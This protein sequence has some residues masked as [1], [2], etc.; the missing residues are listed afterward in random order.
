M[1][2]YIRFVMFATMLVGTLG[3]FCADSVKADQNREASTEVL[4]LGG[5]WS[6][7]IGASA[8]ERVTVSYLSSLLIGRPLP[9]DRSQLEP[10]T[11]VENRLRLGE[12][13]TFRHRTGFFREF[14]IDLQLDLFSGSF[15][16]TLDD[17]L[18]RYDPVQ[19]DGKGLFASTHHHLR[20]LSGEV[21]TMIGRISGGRTT[22]SWGLGILAQ[23]AEDDDPLQFGFKRTGHYVTRLSFATVPAAWFMGDRALADAPLT[24]GFAYDWL[25][26]DDRMSVDD[27]DSGNN[28]IATL[29]WFAK[30]LRLGF[31]GVR[32]TQEND[33]GLTTKAWVADIY[34]M[35][36][37]EL[38]GWRIQL[39]TE[40]AF[41]FGETETFRSYANPDSVDIRQLGGVVRFDV[42]KELFLARL[43]GG[44]AGGDSRPSDD[45]LYAMTF[46]SDYRVGLVLFPEVL[47]RT[48]AVAAYNAQDPRFTGEP[49]VGFD[50]IP[51]RGGVTQAMYINA[52]VGIQ[53]MSNLTVLAGALFARTPEDAVDVYRTNLAGG[54][55]TGPR[56]AVSE[57]SLGVELD[58]AIR[59]RQP[60][61]AGLS[62]MGQFAGGVL[63]P[64]GVFDDA[65][66]N[67]A[68]A[69]GVAVG[70]FAVEGAW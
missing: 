18:L 42:A 58:M 60:L 46:A 7:D 64:G 67:A 19:P 32:R 9:D 23:N 43:E 41:V 8:Q 70:Q 22:N 37:F 48:T 31:F 51:S 4:D 21:T 52:V 36:R 55:P 16:K 49:P 68:P 29:G 44:Y 45:T 40:W 28:I 34:G 57:T 33:D 66:G 47:R 11:N 39:A 30:D 69:V 63:F 54:T 1:V 27:G 25:V 5:G 13:L 26:R 15:A 35:G 3:V 50:D 61:G 24:I 38:D 12:Y 6:F 59:Y 65:E 2:T 10:A 20:K 62:L 53:P 14:K 17:E 56:G